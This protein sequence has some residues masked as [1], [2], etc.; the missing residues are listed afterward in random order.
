MTFISNFKIFISHRPK[1]L[2]RMKGQHD[3]CDLFNMYLVV[4]SG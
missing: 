3:N 1:L 2:A 4:T